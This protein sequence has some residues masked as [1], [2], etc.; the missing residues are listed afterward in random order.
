MRTGNTCVE[1]RRFAFDGT[2]VAPPA[3]LA[4]AAGPAPVV[5]WDAGRWWIA[6]EG[7]TSEVHVLDAGARPDRQRPHGDLRETGRTGA[8]RDARVRASVRVAAET[9]GAA[10]RGKHAFDNGRFHPA[11]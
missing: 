8:Q 4:C 5:T 1:A 2:P 3:T 9:H 10:V 7:A 6:R 11:P